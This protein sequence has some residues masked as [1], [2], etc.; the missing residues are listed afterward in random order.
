MEGG[1]TVSDLARRAGLS[2]RHVAEAEAGRANLSIV[3]L[4]QLAD[5]LDVPL[6]WICDL[7]HAQRHERVALVGLRGA[8][9]TTV[10]RRLALDLEVPFIE[11][12]ERVE[13]LAG[14]SLAE[15]FDLHGEQTYRRF[16]AEALE[17]VLASGS[18][19]I[20]AAGG[21]I[22]TSEA[23]YSRLRG[24]CRSVWLRA[25]PSD[26]LE[27]VLSQGDGRPMA[28]RPRAIDELKSILEQRGPLYG[29]C[30]THIETSGRN[31]VDVTQEIVAWLRAAS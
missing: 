26:H 30:D 2:R 21:S 1:Y 24:A 3:K 23:T 22:V 28:G 27:R 19:S 10:G 18:R 6:A 20:I 25:D 29:M 8:G 12:D 7:R 4:A 31:T 9:K 5:A 16:E 11:L 14:L 17:M 13:Q 15:I